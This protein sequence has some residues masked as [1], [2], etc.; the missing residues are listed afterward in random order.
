VELYLHTLYVL[1]PC[2]LVKYRIRFHGVVQIYLYIIFESSWLA[3]ELASVKFAFRKMQLP[4]YLST[5]LSVFNRD[6]DRVQ[7]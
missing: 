7:K 5:V 4:L 1:I 6:K 3:K 2:C